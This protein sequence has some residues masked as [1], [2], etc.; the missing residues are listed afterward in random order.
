V[1]KP[2]ACSSGD[3]ASKADGPARLLWNDASLWTGL[4]LPKRGGLVCA[5][6]PIINLPGSLI[7]GL[8]PLVSFGYRLVLRDH[9]AILRGRAPTAKPTSLRSETS[10]NVSPKSNWTTCHLLSQKRDL[11]KP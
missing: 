5:L 6:V 8:G 10:G 3:H 7:P 2:Y 1:T 9:C 11:E 4:G